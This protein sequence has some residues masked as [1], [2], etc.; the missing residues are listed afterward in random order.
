MTTKK[1]DDMTSEELGLM[2]GQFF[3]QGFRLQQNI[4]SITAEL[5]RRQATIEQKDT[6]NDQQG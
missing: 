6:L 1:I 3:E 4:H 2:L 5:K